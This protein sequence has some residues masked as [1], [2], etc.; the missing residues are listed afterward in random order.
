MRYLLL[1]RLVWRLIKR[2]K[3][4]ERFSLFLLIFYNFQNLRPLFEPTLFQR[5]HVSF[6]G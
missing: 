6:R 5:G 2:Q 4:Q 1:F 3:A